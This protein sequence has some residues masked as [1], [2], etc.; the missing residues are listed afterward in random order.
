M[1]ATLNSVATIEGLTSNHLIVEVMP[2]I[3]RNQG[4]QFYYLNKDNKDIQYINFSEFNSKLTDI[5]KKN[6]T[7][8][9]TFCGINR[10]DISIPDYLYLTFSGKEVKYEAHNNKGVFLEF[11]FNKG[12]DTLE[13]EIKRLFTNNIGVFIQA[14]L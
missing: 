1:P 12:G 11:V 10:N 7:F 13:N 6:G 2:N 8:Y 9:I 5:L 3:L 4:L 14:Y